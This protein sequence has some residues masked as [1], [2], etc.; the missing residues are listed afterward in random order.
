MTDRFHLFREELNRIMDRNIERNTRRVKEDSYLRDESMI[1]SILLEEEENLEPIKRMM[2]QED[3]KILHVI[4]GM[5]V[6]LDPDE[7]H[8]KGGWNYVIKCPVCGKF[9]AT[10]ARG[11]Y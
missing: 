9:G 4:E 1:K 5:R 7:E 8:P 10:R 3:D 11:V 2:I 6:E